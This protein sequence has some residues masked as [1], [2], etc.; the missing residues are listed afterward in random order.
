MTILQTMN[1]DT[2]SQAA[3]VSD[4]IMGLI[5]L[6]GWSESEASQRAAISVQEAV[7]RVERV[8]KTLKVAIMQEITAADITLIH[9]G[10]GCDYK[11]DKMDDMYMDTSGATTNN[12]GQQQILCM[13]GVGLQRDVSKRS[14]NGTMKCHRE[15]VLKPK[16]ALYSVLLNGGCPDTKADKVLSATDGKD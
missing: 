3:F 14:E 12:G 4:I 11:V 2:Q 1:S 9:V 7:L 10:A 13:V 5:Y 8:W 16:V 6:C 15:V